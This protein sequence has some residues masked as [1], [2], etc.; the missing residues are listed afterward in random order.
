[1]HYRRMLMEKMSKLAT[2]LLITVLTASSLLAVKVANGLTKPSVP[3]FTVRFVDASYDIPT[4]Y[5]T[6]PYTEAN[7][8]HPGYH[9]QN[10]TIEVAIKNQPFTPYQSDDQTINFYLNIR[11]KAHYATEWITIYNPDRG[12]ITQSN[13]EYTKV[14][15]SL[16]DNIFP[17]WNNVPSGGIVD[18]Q[19]Q[20]LIG[21]THRA[22]NSSETDQLKMYPWVFTGEMSGWSNTQSVTVFGTIVSPTPTSTPTATT[23]QN[24]FLIESN[25]TVSAFSFNNTQPEIFF[26]V[27]GPDN[28]TGFVKLSIAKIFMPNA[29]NI[30]VYLDGNP[31][32]HDVTSNGDSWVI[33]FTYQHSAHQ[34]IISSTQTRNSSGA[35]DWI[36]TLTIAV[37]AIALSIAAV[38]V[39][40][41]A[42]KKT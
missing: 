12:Y 40:W 17:F 22:Y 27:T 34:V 2:L 18:F 21:Y 35:P 5:S 13:S 16:D 4:T 36:L 1:M 25:S 33:F 39:V 20:A 23:N 8:T 14:T 11:T 29:D 41:V 26:T 30:R 15:F 42:K 32:S 7:V 6:D 19:V 9:V 38:I 31:V 28:T 37:V 10:R 3:E 24:S